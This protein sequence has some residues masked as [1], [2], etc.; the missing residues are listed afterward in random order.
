MSTVT[1]GTDIFEDF[2][3]DIDATTEKQYG[4]YSFNIRVGV[5]K[6]A[7]P[8]HERFDFIRDYGVG[9][10]DKIFNNETI[11]E[12]HLTFVFPE[13]YLSVHEQQSFTY[14]LMQHKDISN[15]KHVD[16]LTSSPLMIGSFHKE[17]IRILTWPD[18]NK[19]NG[20]LQ[21]K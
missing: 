21:N 16:I 15:I 19:H 13:R 4:T 12:T 9:F 3:G 1:S 14:T 10:L 7:A 8:R 17:T 18:D 6:M 2:L 5:V 11:T 20:Q